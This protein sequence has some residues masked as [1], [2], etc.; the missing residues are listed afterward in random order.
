MTP[1]SFNAISA[2]MSYRASYDE[3]I[4]EDS[5]VMRDLWQTTDS[6]YGSYLSHMKQE[7]MNFANQSRGNA[8]IFMV[9]VL[10]FIA[11]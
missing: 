6:R 3:K 5:W 10:F 4:T 11:K 2:W 1:E 8:A 7:F 9:T